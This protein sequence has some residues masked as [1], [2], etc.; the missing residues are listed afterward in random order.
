MKTNCQGAF[1]LKHVLRAVWIALVLLLVPPISSAQA[2]EVS[3]P[4]PDLTGRW[5]LV[6]DKEPNE[7]I[8]AD[9]RYPNQRT[10]ARVPSLGYEFVL[11][12]SGQ[13]LTIDRKFNELNVV[14]KVET[15]GVKA[16]NLL[17]GIPTVWTARW[18]GPRLIVTESF[19]KSAE[20]AFDVPVTRTIWLEKDGTLKIET[21][22]LTNR[23]KQTSTYSKA[24]DQVVTSSAPG[25]SFAR[26]PS[27]PDD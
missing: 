21:E 19:E 24:R 20:S 11:S 2:Q 8:V 6:P 16:S 14:V 23:P 12:L 5:V 26:V 13:T 22:G 18:D 1:L 9:P 15:T 25:S 3:P 7:M 10:P 27:R 17:L 4:R